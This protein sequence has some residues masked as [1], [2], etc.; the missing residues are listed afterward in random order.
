MNRL[1]EELPFSE[2]PIRLL[3]SRKTRKSLQDM[4]D[5]GRSAAR[6]KPDGVEGIDDEIWQ[7]EGANQPGPD[8]ANEMDS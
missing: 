1:R 7:E 5:T 3:F 6:S 8:K 2:V 4:R